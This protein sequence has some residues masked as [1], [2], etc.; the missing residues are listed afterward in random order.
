MGNEMQKTNNHRPGRPSRP[1]QKSELLLIARKEFARLGY[2][3]TSLDAVARAAGLRKASL[4]HHF[5]SK[6][7]LYLET[8]S[9][10]VGELLSLVEKARLAEG[11]YLER[12]DRL[13]DKVTDYLAHNNDAA[14]L[15]LMEL[16]G[17]GPY[18]QGVG[19]T[20]VQLALQ[21]IERFLIS[22]MNNGV[23]SPQNAYQLALSIVGLHLFY[24]AGADT[25]SFIRKQD[26]L[27]PQ[28]VMERRQAVRQQVRALCGVTS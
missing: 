13:G 7:Q 23:F 17:Q 24:F 11:D 19:R 5:S 18:L 4:L 3:A 21:A 22:G 15:L 12:L 10:V 20:H 16:T 27:S 6:E 1:F 8:L 9:G 25:F 14:R 2:N 26:T 28:M